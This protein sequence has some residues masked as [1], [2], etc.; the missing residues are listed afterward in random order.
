VGVFLG[1]QHKSAVFDAIFYFWPIVA[2]HKMKNKF[3]PISIFTVGRN[4]I[5]LVKNFLLQKWT[6]IVVFE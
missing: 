5:F 3:W 1:F 2:D 6:F 4:L